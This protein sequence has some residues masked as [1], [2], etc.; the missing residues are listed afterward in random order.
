MVLN[1][2]DS[3]NIDR[4]IASL[5]YLKRLINE[6]KCVFRKSLDSFTISATNFGNAAAN[7]TPNASI[8]TGNNVPISAAGDYP[9]SLTFACHE[10]FIKLTPFLRVNAFMP[11]V[12]KILYAATPFLGIHLDG[13]LNDKH[14]GMADQFENLA[15]FYLSPLLEAFLHHDSVNA[16]L[17][18]SLAKTRIC[19]LAIYV[20]YSL[21]SITKVL[22]P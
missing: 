7:F 5:K 4:I 6:W 18:E 17:E 2:L 15:A 13:I 3:E 22:L 19:S 9:I 14:C 12:L 8:N 16:T 10:L 11:S 21:R 1:G 20:S